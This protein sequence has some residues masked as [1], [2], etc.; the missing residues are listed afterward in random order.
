MSTDIRDWVR[1]FLS[2]V[3]KGTVVCYYPEDDDHRDPTDILR[4]VMGEPISTGNRKWG[5]QWYR[6]THA[7]QRHESQPIHECDGCQ[8]ATD[9]SIMGRV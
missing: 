8:Q 1:A 4:A 2:Q 5:G 7:C 3:D 6:V 9:D